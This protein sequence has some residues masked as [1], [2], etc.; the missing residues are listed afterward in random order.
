MELIQGN[1]DDPAKQEDLVFL[2]GWSDSYKKHKDIIERAERIN[3]DVVGECR[4]VEDGANV[5]YLVLE[6][7]D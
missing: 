7:K 5:F 1:T 2:P 6:K 4:T 3:F